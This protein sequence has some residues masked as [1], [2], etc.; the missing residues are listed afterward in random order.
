MEWGTRDYPF[1]LGEGAAENGAFSSR[2]VEKA[3]VPAQGPWISMT[4][5][6]NYLLKTTYL[7]P[8]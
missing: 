4:W 6:R 1:I 3:K 7:L 2:L 8:A 5:T